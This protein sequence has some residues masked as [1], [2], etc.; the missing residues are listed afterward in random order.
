MSVAISILQAKTISK[1]NYEPVYIENPIDREL[2]ICK[3]LNGNEFKKLLLL[4]YN[5]LDSMQ[6]KQFHLAN[7]LDSEY[8]KQLGN[9]YRITVTK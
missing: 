3:N 8:L 6:N 4:A 9:K 2:N 1:P 5:S 7:L